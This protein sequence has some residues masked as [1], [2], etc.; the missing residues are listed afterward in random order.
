MRIYLITFFKLHEETGHTLRAHKRRKVEIFSSMKI[1]IT[2]ALYYRYIATKR[3]IL[4]RN[5]SQ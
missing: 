4:H 3:E 2:V 1:S 5:Q